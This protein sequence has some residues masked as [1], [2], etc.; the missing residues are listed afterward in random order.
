MSPSNTWYTP[1]GILEEFY[2][3]GKQVYY[4]SNKR[5]SANEAFKLIKEY[6]R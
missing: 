4:L 2:W 6:P 3:A 5:I 1:Y